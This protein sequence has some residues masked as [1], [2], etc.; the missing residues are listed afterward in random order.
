MEI[1]PTDRPASPPLPTTP[2][3][4]D[5]YFA[6]ALIYADRCDDYLPAFHAF[7]WNPDPKKYRS[8]NPHEQYRSLLYCVLFKC[9]KVF[10]KFVFVSE[11]TVNGNIH[12][13]GYYA[14]IDPTKYYKWF[15]PA[16]KDWGNTVIKDN[17]N[18]YWT[19]QYIP[20]SVKQMTE[21][22]AEY[23]DIPI[24]L[25]EYN[26][27]EYIEK[28]H[29]VVAHYKTGR[30]ITRKSMYSMCKWKKMFALSFAMKNLK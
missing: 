15:V 19:Y 20:K 29:G 23:D 27:D 8:T 12:V 16:C 25:T 26:I 7:T 5:W 17:I 30:V 22:F 21:L 3:S 11:L 9:K 28:G 18:D 13:H 4:K 14:V 1:P 6:E 10:S 24:L 2:K